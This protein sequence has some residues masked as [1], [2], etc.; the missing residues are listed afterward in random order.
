MTVPLCVWWH[1]LFLSAFR[2]FRCRR[3][4]LACGDG[5]LVWWARLHFRTQNLGRVIDKNAE[6]AHKETKPNLKVLFRCRSELS[7][8]SRNFPPLLLGVEPVSYTKKAFLIRQLQPL[9]KTF[10]SFSACWWEEM[11]VLVE[12]AA[13]L[14]FKFSSTVLSYF[15]LFVHVRQFK[16]CV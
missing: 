10:E 4:R 6:F 3:H 1:S 2:L 5:S 13:P 11:P 14:F 16:L 8:I 7:I 12:T 9:K 15:P